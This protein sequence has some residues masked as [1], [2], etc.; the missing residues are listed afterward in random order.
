[1]FDKE[2]VYDPKTQDF[3]MYLDG[4]FIGYARTY[5]GGEDILNALV[6]DRLTLN[7]VN[8]AAEDSE[9]AA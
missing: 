3:A 6:F 5:S 8:D 2:L 1:M 9:V 7:A 4:E